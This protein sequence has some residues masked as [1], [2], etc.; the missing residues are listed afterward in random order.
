M[1]SNQ[2]SNI[3]PGWIGGFA[4]SN[5]AFDYPDPDLT[6]IPMTGNMDYIRR[7]TRQQ[8]VWWPEFSW[9]TVPGKPASR[10]F[11]RFAHDISRIGYDDTGRTWSIICPQQGHC[12]HDFACMNVEVSVTGQRGWVDET[13][14]TL[15]AD[16]TVEGKIWFTP[17]SLSNWLVKEAWQIFDRHHLSFPFDKAHAIQVTTHKK[18]DPSQPIFPV[19]K[20]QSP[21]FEAPKFA[22]HPKAWDIGH[23]EVEIGPILKTNHETVDTFNEKV[24]DLFNLAS[25]NMLKAGNTLTW[26][27]WFLAPQLVNQEEWRTHA[28]RWRKSLDA[29]HQPGG[30]G[31]APR[32]ADGNKFKPERP[33]EEIFED[34]RDIIESLL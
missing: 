29:E 5:P 24:L 25:G 22:Q 3:P 31:R 8:E 6:S 16:M 32:Y 28:E 7:L 18:G 4:Q 20:G 14:Q 23:L 19:R 30:P 33:P 26:N 1:T 12:I 34:L 11:T 10:C 21:L 15:A 17:S 13:N 27:V 9:E 2:N